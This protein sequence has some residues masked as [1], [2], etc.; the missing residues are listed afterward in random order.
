[1]QS[2]FEAPALSAIE[3]HEPEVAL[4]PIVFGIPAAPAIQQLEPDVALPRSVFDTP[5]ADLVQLNEP[6]V[7]YSFDL[8]APVPVQPDVLH[9]GAHHRHISPI[10]AHPLEAP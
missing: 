10:V 8:H 5:A 6:D 2:A 7:P 9:V 3:L 4:L 1:M